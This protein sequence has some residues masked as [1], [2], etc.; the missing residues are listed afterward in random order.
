MEYPKSELPLLRAVIPSGTSL[1]P[2][3]CHAGG[4]HAKYCSSSSLLTIPVTKPAKKSIYSSNKKPISSPIKSIIPRPQ[5][6]LLLSHKILL[7][8]HTTHL[9]LDHTAHL[10][11]NHNQPPSGNKLSATWPQSLSIP[12]ICH[13]FWPPGISL[14]H[15]STLSRSSRPEPCL[16]RNLST[17][18]SR[19]RALRASS[20]RFSQT[21]KSR[22]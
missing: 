4:R 15:P 11:L 16:L 17:L 3:I 8:D 6:H 10:L 18:P 21:R 2:P 14:Q 19:N 1:C 13:I 7:F 9:L 5:P 22:R 12:R 20:H